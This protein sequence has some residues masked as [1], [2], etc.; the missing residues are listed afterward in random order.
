VDR[1]FFA[2]FLNYKTVHSSGDKV[3]RNELKPKS[4]KKNLSEIKVQVIIQIKYFLKT[5]FI[6]LNR[7]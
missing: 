6:K 7:I 5:K 1:N 3:V 4:R 2:N